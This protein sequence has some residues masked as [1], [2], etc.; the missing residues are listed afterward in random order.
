MALMFRRLLAAPEYRRPL[1]ILLVFQLLV[2]AGAVG[3]GMVQA[4]RVRQDERER[5]AA[6]L[7]RLETGYPQAAEEA[8][9][10]LNHGW[11]GGDVRKGRALLERYG[12]GEGPASDPY[13]LS[14]LLPLLFLL[15]L[16]GTAAVYHLSR[17]PFFRS[18][19]ELSA[20]V[21]ANLEGEE[22]RIPAVYDEGE[23]A[24][25]CCRINQLVRKLFAAT[26]AMQREQLF[27]ERM[28]SDISH[29]LKT[30]MSSLVMF[31]DLML[32]EPEM[33][34]ETRTEFLDRSRASLEKMEVLVASLLKLARLESG[35]VSFRRIPID[36]PELIDTSI[37][38]VSALAGSRRVEI[39][40]EISA[41]AGAG[42]APGMHGDPFWLSEALTNV[43]KNGLEHTP[44]GGRVFISASRTPLFLRLIVQNEGE[45]IPEADLPRLFERFFSGSGERA[46]IGLALARRVVR[47][48]GGD[49]RAENTDGEG[50]RFIFTFPD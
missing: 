29:Q 19:D 26:D 31:N 48:H 35:S 42:E 20:A 44:P 25:F 14:A 18:L 7:G 17:H 2:L 30:P 15:S 33:D 27:L 10:L 49:L 32:R 38:A 11:S 47:D 39:L 16:S 13:P 23:W 50:V 1:S 40:T 9:A 5:L 22:C 37:A 43:L 12:F 34:P 24:L 4:E 45:A 8:A 46:G 28:L 6:L 41:D 3:W 21:Q 36:L